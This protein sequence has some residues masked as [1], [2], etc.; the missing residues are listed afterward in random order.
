MKILKII[1]IVAGL[2]WLTQQPGWSQERT[3]LVKAEL[4]ETLS[5]Q[6]SVT[7][8]EE[9]KVITFQVG[10]KEVSF[11]LNYN[12][13][14][15]GDSGTYYFDTAGYQLSLGYFG[16]GTIFPT[17]LAKMNGDS[18]VEIA[19]TGINWLGRSKHQALGNIWDS[20]RTFDANLISNEQGYA[21][22]LLNNVPVLVVYHLNYSPGKAID[23]DPP[24]YRCTIQEMYLPGLKVNFEEWEI[25]AIDSDPGIDPTVVAEQLDRRDFHD[26]A[27]RDYVGHHHY[28][29]DQ[30][31]R[32]ASEDRI[33]FP[34]TK[35]K[36]I[37]LGMPIRRTGVFTFALTDH[38]D[39]EIRH[40]DYRLTID[41]DEWP[42]NGKIRE[43]KTGKDVEGTLKRL[44]TIAATILSVDK[45]DD[46]GKTVTFSFDGVKYHL[47]Y[48]AT[49]SDGL[50][51]SV[52]KVLPNG[53]PS[54]NL[55][56]SADGEGTNA[57]KLTGL[58]V[59]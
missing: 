21:F 37:E 17:R 3:V 25:S 4:K 5:A 24:D 53:R 14:W 58:Q 34:V 18:R 12:P 16:D 55:N 41:Q 30:P 56:F 57:V 20:F 38:F 47:E 43:E 46:K 32:V 28:V 23:L 2:F 44:G 26:W 9:D 48:D 59:N 40:P 29:D 10:D 45:Q 42:I 52:L 6:E 22:F 1:P 50:Y 7:L 51:L 36:E 39:L 27:A 13:S 49:G 54:L 33:I 19:R 11:S 8:D 31:V 15:L 35:D